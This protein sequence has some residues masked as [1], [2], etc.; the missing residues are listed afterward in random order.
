MSTTHLELERAIDAAP[1]A[2]SGYLVYGDW[3]QERGHPRGVLVALDRELAQDPWGPRGVEL[4]RERAELLAGGADELMGPLAALEAA[5][6]LTLDWHLGFVRGASL[7]LRRSS[8]EE[9]LADLGRVLAHPSLRFVRALELGPLELRQGTVALERV[10]SL[11]AA[12]PRPTLLRLVLGRHHDG[13]WP[14]LPD[15]GPLLATA[16]AL[17]ELVLLGSANGLPPIAHEPLR[18]LELVVL[19]L[20]PSQLEVARRCPRLETLHLSL[21]ESPIAQAGA[22]ELARTLPASLQE[23]GLLAAPFGDALCRELPAALAGSALRRLDLSLGAITD[24]GAAALRRSREAGWSLEVSLRDNRIGEEEAAALAALPGVEVGPQDSADAAPSMLPERARG[25]VWDRLR[26]GQQGWTDLEYAAGLPFYESARRISVA[27]GDLRNEQSAVRGLG[28]LCQNLGRLD[29]SIT[30]RRLAVVL[31]RRRRERALEPLLDLAATHRMH[32]HV[33]LAQEVFEEALAAAEKDDDREGASRAQVG[34][35]GVKVAMGQW[36]EA[37][38]LCRQVARTPLGKKS[39]SVWNI[40]GAAEQRLGDYAGAVQSYERA[41]EL[42]SHPPNKIPIQL[43]LGQVHWQR[44]ARDEAEGIYREAAKAAR[45]QR[46]LEMAGSALSS[47]GHLYL[48][49][50]RLRQA[51]EALLEALPLLEQVQSRAK[52]G[53]TVTHLGILRIQQARLQE[54]EELLLR[55]REVHRETGNRQWEAIAIGEL[56]GAA[57]DQGQLD[58]CA[59]LCAE[60]IA[61]LRA[62]G[63]AWSEATSHCQLGEVHLARNEPAEARK[64]YERSRTL[65]AKVGNRRWVAWSEQCL[66]RVVHERGAHDEALR[67]YDAALAALQAVGDQQMLGRAQ[68]DRAGFLFT[69]GEREQATAALKAG[70]H[71]LEVSGDATG[72]HLA[73]LCEQFAEELARG[74]PR[75]AAEGDHPYLAWLRH[76]AARRSKPPERPGRPGRPGRASQTRR[77]DDSR[78]EMRG[79]RGKRGKRGKR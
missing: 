37:R 24:E 63:D 23:L 29:E 30:H 47:L 51:E 20:Q 12:A 6:E 19:G 17:R 8:S 1:E 57:I 66:A 52:V 71:L 40:L 2:D 5:G 10:A 46:F 53:E 27:T 50:G 67:L 75:P 45:E 32:G 55:A 79:G 41:L 21:G 14:P 26:R 70:R 69:R 48:N 44:G 13:R 73:E 36:A 77:A 65:S 54:A 64:C 7:G 25:A 3:L 76:G 56:A 28:A 43:N 62:L 74:A 42:E 39:S 9:L 60:S 16:P 33:L 35:A 58:R 49:S 31:T 11:L 59:E 15:L 22:L 18:R 61:I 34:L 4:R 38:G 78:A 72:M 68:V